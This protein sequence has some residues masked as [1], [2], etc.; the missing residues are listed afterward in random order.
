MPTQEYHSAHTE[1]APAPT[2]TDLQLTNWLVELLHDPERLV[3]AAPAMSGDLPQ[4]DPALPDATWPAGPAGLSAAT[5]KTLIPQLLHE[6]TLISTRRGQSGITKGRLVGL[7]HQNITD[8]TA[9]ALMIW[10]DQAGILA[11]PDAN[12]SPWR[13]PRP[14]AITDADQITERL[15]ATPH[16][17]PDAIRTAYGGER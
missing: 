9:R 10:F 14:F 15:R 4:E 2:I 11:P 3:G 12:Q 1:I 13:A 8:A 6:P 16:P 17:Q 7:R 5:L